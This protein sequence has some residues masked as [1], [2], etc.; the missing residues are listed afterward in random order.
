MR[1][2]GELWDQIRSGLESCHWQWLAEWEACSR[3]LSALLEQQKPAWDQALLWR[4]PAGRLESLR[5]L[6]DHDAELTLLTA[7][8]ALYR[9][10]PLERLAQAALRC[11][12]Q[13]EELIR[14]LPVNLPTSRGEMVAVLGREAGIGW[15]RAAWLSWRDRPVSLSLHDVSREALERW[16]LER[17]A[18]GGAF[19]RLSAILA[20][21]LAVAWEALS[22]EAL[23][24]LSGRRADTRP[25]RRAGVRWLRRLSRASRRSEALLEQFRAG[26]RSA[27]AR[28]AS[29]LFRGAERAAGHSD[30]AERLEQDFERW[31]LVVRSAGDQLRV[32]QAL[33]VAGS[34][35]TAEAARCLQSLR[36]EEGK[37]VQELDAL[38][39]WLEQLQQAAIF[40][41]AP[42]PEAE[43]VAAEV[44]IRNWLD[45][46]ESQLHSLLPEAIEIPLPRNELL[47]L[48]KTPRLVPVRAPLFSALRSSVKGVALP[49]FRQAEMLH[50]ALLGDVER[51]RKVVEYGHEAFASRETP[52]DELAREAI[53]NALLLLRHRRSTLP[54]ATRAVEEAFCR[55]IAAA[56][57]RFHLLFELRRGGVH[58]C[59]SRHGLRDTFW[60]VRALA[61]DAIREWWIEF[62]TRLQMGLRAWIGRREREVCWDSRPRVIARTPVVSLE[63]PAAPV[64]S[65]LYFRLFDLGPLRDPRLLVGREAEMA[66]IAAARDR[67]ETGRA[68]SIL[69][70][71]P[72]GS[73]KT[74]LLNCAALRVLSSAPILRASFRSRVESVAQMQEFLRSLFSL[75]A[76]EPVNAPALAGQRVIVLLE[77][78][79]RAFLRRPGGYD[80]LRYLLHLVASTSRDVLWICTVNQ[81]CF[82]LLEP[83]LGLSRFFS[84][85]IE[86]AAVRPAEIEEAIL[87]RHRL[88]GL[89]LY[90]SA[91]DESSHQP[92]W[93]PWLSPA[94]EP[95]RLV[96]RALHQ[97]SQGIFRLALQTWLQSV[98]RIE[99]GFVY[100]R[101]P[102]V[103]DASKSL[104]DVADDSLF[105]LLAL[106]QH[107]G[108]TAAEH[109]ALFALPEPES[110]GR[111]DALLEA[112]LIEPDPDA[113]FRVAP[114]ATLEVE[115]ELTRRNLL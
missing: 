23:G 12:N 13:I 60:I 91:A 40:T 102:A 98:Q 9:N 73:G 104:A 77:E 22:R 113:G 1:S 94:P 44:R 108:L 71:G 7:L 14:A 6:F 3:E 99:G 112:G 48:S 54:A 10:R 42:P 105:S 50:R 41:P 92:R 47:R 26:V 11:C 90:V 46:V 36:D 103:P 49:A 74:S 38:I 95:E 59:L 111:L 75:P 17:A 86:A 4:R 62:T 93:F 33:T 27:P 30:F 61:R 72:A 110:Q 69:I 65:Q 67:W 63:L 29:A 51:A 82:A 43:I 57:R 35:A 100:V 37:L 88:S 16:L 24:R 70:V 107:G 66:A 28:L 58:G 21:E 32:V 81:T 76:G 79:E 84:F 80:G 56:F 39:R 115:R 106:L 78:L 53:S 15:I 85:R 18:A 114:H 25:L 97:R 52:A 87:L 101:P 109:A 64:A 20:L 96:F 55:A 83:L 19:V 2:L 89:R 68:A 5:E 45:A 34:R 31:L 8:S